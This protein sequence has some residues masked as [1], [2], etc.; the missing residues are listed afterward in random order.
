MIETSRLRLRLHEAT[1]FQAL[2]RMW[3]DPR[4]T[5]F[6]GGE[7]NPPNEVWRR[8][9]FYRGHWQLLGFGFWIVEERHSRSF[10][11]E[12]GFANF[13]RG[14]GETDGVREAGW[15]LNPDCFGRGFATEAM[16]AATAWLREEF[17]P[18]RT[19]C[20][21]HPENVPSIALASRLGYRKLGVV[22]FKGT[23]DVFER[24]LE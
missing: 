1:D 11:G 18:Q 21:I 3:G 10:V 19:V 17:G 9:M 8:L 2:Q 5:Q 14:L 15:C 24:V 16:G 22:D 23:T 7:P 12:L 6:I 20:I 13:E 4:V